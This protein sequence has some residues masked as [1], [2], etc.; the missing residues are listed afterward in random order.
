MFEFITLLLH[1]NAKI[2]FKVFS[3]LKLYLGY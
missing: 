2:N 3:I 1:L